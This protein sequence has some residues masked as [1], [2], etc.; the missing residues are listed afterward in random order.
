MD[1]QKLRRKALGKVSKQNAAA[2]KNDFIVFSGTANRKLSESIAQLLEIDLGA[3]TID[4]FPDGE[5][6]LHLD[7][8]VRGRDIFLVQSTCAPVDEHLVEV[9]AFAD[10]CRRSGASRVTL[11]APYLGYARS[12]KRQGRRTPLI[13]SM[14][15]ELLQTIGVDRVVTVDLHAAQIEGFFRIPV[16]SLTAVPALCH[17]FEQSRSE[18]VVI[19]S[20]D[21]GRVK[22]AGAYAARLKSR[23]VVL[24]K[25]RLSESGTTAVTHVVGDVKDAPCLIIDDIISTG[26]TIKQA[27]DALLKA[28]SRPDI[29]VAA[30]HGVLV[31]PARENLRH[32]AIRAIYITNS[33]PVENANWPELQVVSL[34]PLLTAAIRRLVADESMADLFSHVIHGGRDED[35]LTAK[36]ALG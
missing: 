8:P 6:N 21:A 1:Q 12:D 3:A 23:V 17:A 4:R 35:S 29:T 14:V 24:H 13:A 7:T 26:G 36:T 31:G 22:M 25:E 20:P 34:A 18:G 28:G 27:V 19:V 30:S 33:V 5:L 10:A 2:M 15:A 32:A 11:I 9:L 16:D